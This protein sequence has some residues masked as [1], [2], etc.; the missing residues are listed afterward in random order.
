MTTSKRVLALT[1]ALSLALGLV[2]ATMSTTTPA[3]AAEECK[4]KKIGQWTIYTINN[5]QSY[6][7]VTGSEEDA[8]L[9]E[10][11]GLP[12]L[13]TTTTTTTATTTTTTTTTTLPQDDNDDAVTG[14]NT[15]SIRTTTDG[16]G[17]G[18]GDVNTDSV[19]T[20][21][22][23][24]SWEPA[25]TVEPANPS[26]KGRWSQFKFTM[27][28]APRRDRTSVLVEVYVPRF[29]RYKTFVP[30]KSATKV[31]GFRAQDDD[32]STI[33]VKILERNNHDEYVVGS[34]SSASVTVPAASD[35]PTVNI[36]KHETTPSIEE[37]G[38]ARFLITAD[39]SIPAFWDVMVD[40]SQTNG[41]F[42]TQLG[43]QPVEFG[44]G[45]TSVIFEVET[46][47]DDVC[48]DDGQII[49]ELSDSVIYTV[50]S[51]DSAIVPVTDD[52]RERAPVST[53]IGEGSLTL[54]P[55][56]YSFAGRQWTNKR[57]RT[58]RVG[59]WKLTWD[60][61][62]DGDNVLEANVIKNFTTNLMS[63]F[64]GGTFDCYTTIC[65]ELNHAIRN[66]NQC[67][68]DAAERM[69]RWGLERIRDDEDV[70]SGFPDLGDCHVVEWDDDTPTFTVSAHRSTVTEGDE[71]RFDFDWTTPNGQNPER[72]TVNLR[73]VTVGSFLEEEP[74]ST[75]VLGKN[76]AFSHR[77]KY[78]TL[79]LE[80]DNDGVV[81]RFG[82]VQ[83]IILPPSDDDHVYAVGEDSTAI[84][85]VLDDDEAVTFT[86]TTPA[87]VVEGNRLTFSVSVTKHAR[88]G[89]LSVSVTETG[90]MLK[91]DRGHPPTQVNISNGN[92]TLYVDTVNDTHRECPS[93]ISVTSTDPRIGSSN[94]ASVTV[95]D[96]E[97]PD[98]DG[99]TVS[100]MPTRRG[101]A[102]TE[103]QDASFTIT[104]TDSSKA[105]PVFYRVTLGTS[106]G[107]HSD[108]RCAS[109]QGTQTVSI[110]TS[111]DSV[112][113]PDGPLTVSLSSSHPHYTV[114]SKSPSASVTVND[115]DGGVTVAAPSAQIGSAGNVIAGDEFGVW[116][117]FCNEDDPPSR[118]RVEVERPGYSDKH[119]WVS[120]DHT[121]DCWNYGFFH[122][123]T[124]STGTARITVVEGDGYT[125]GASTSITITAAGT[126]RTTARQTVS[127]STGGGSPV[128]FT[129]PTT[130]VNDEVPSAPRS[131]SGSSNT[132]GTAVSLSWSVPSNYGTAAISG[133]QYRYKLSS[134][135]SWTSWSSQSSTSVT[136]SGLS[137]G[138]SY[139]FEVRASNSA[140][141]GEAA[142]T[143][144]AT[145]VAALPVLSVSRYQSGV[146]EGGTAYFRVTSD[147][148]VPSSISVG[149]SRSQ[150]G[151][152]ASWSGSGTVTI[153][154]GN[155]RSGW[156]SVSTVDD[157]T[158]EPNGSLTLTLNSGTGYTVGSPSSV[159]VTVNDDDVAVLPVLSVSRYQS[160]V[161]E[162]GTAYFRVTSD[163][164]VP[165]SISVGFS[166]SQSGSFASWSGSGT[167][168][169]S[170]GNTRSGWIAVTTQNDSVDEPNGSL[171]LTLNSG[172]GYTVG[173]PSSVSVT[174]NDDDV[175][176]LPVLSVSR[177]QSSVTEGSTAYFRVTSD[178][179]VPSSI[180][181]GFSRSQQGSFA[182]WSGSGTVT[183]SSG[184]T[185]SGWISVST[186][187][188]STDEPNGSLTL[189]LNSG[190][191]YTVGSPSSVSVT[192][193]D[194]DVAVLPVL[195]VSRYQS[196]VT[197]GSTAYFRV[198]S[199][200]V[201][202]SSISVGFSR[203]QQG[204]FASWSGSGT[205]TISSGNTRSGWISVST[206]NDS[207]DEP[208]G[209]LTL[210]LNSGTGYTV[211]SPSSVSVTVN[212]DD[213]AV[214]P[215][216][217]VSRYQSGVTEGGTAYF[218][219]TSD[220]SVPSSI[221]VGFS[222]S[223]SGSFASWSGSGTVTISSGNTRSGWIA[224]TTQN[225]SVDEP[226]GSL[227]LTLNSGTGYTVGSPSSA[228]ITVRDNDEAPVT[229]SSGQ[230]KKNGV[231]GYPVLTLGRETSGVT[232]GERVRFKIYSDRPVTRSTNVKVFRQERG[233]FGISTGTSSVGISAG[234]GPWSFSYSTT[235]DSTDESDGSVQASLRYGSYYTPGSPSSASVAIRDNDDP[236]AVISTVSISGGRAVTEGENVVFTLTATPR[237][238][239][240]ISVRV[241]IADPYSDDP[242]ITIFLTDYS[243]RTVRIGTSG[244]ATLSLATDDDQE[245]ERDDDVVATIKPSASE[246][247]IGTASA[248][249]R[250]RDNDVADTCAYGQTKKNGSCGYPILTVER[251]SSSVTE[252][253]AAQFRIRSDRRVPN[254]ISVNYQ[255]S[256]SGSFGISARNSAAGSFRGNGPWVFSLSTSNDSVD[257]PDGSV[258][259]SLRSGPRYRVGNQSSAT[260]TIRDNDAPVSTA[261]PTGQTRKNSVCGYPVLTI[262]KVSS[263]ITEGQTAN[264]NIRSDRR[265]PAS[266]RVQLYRSTSAGFGTSGSF[267]LGISSGTG[268]W[269]F[270]YLTVGDSVDEANGSVN[271]TLRSGTRYSVGSPWSARVVI[272]D[273]DSA[274]TGDDDDDD[275][276]GNDEDDG[277]SR[278]G[279]GNDDDDDED[280]A[281][282]LPSARA[283]NR[284][285]GSI[286]AGSQLSF[287]VGFYK[288]ENPPTSI[289]VKVERPGY[290]TKYRWISLNRTSGHW[291]YG[292]FTENTLSSRTGTARITV[293]STSSY[294]GG[295]T[296]TV[297]ITN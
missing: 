286:T 295:A 133:Y 140:G 245:D 21:T 213:V 62:L 271:M 90:N 230:A 241:H 204:S 37:G 22:L 289:R 272:Y 236:P 176:V 288:W 177:Y 38:V 266:L 65:Q 39:K 169:I 224:V 242:G 17:G 63:Y 76:D 269:A 18:T 47:P 179:V 102:I 72:R 89:I 237:P 280:A 82:T 159:S 77:D 132:A 287:W 254:S 150:Q 240:A 261:C 1:I 248:S 48:E 109:V 186:V 129:S 181:V 24:T 278:S 43:E 223:Q 93:T 214:L 56:T 136:I 19:T 28:P 216:L 68:N 251:V 111:D 7:A 52:D 273:D 51:N 285:S 23:G 250:V 8:E 88:D 96:Y 196:S 94:T 20:Q 152:F 233:N 210:T 180:S 162:G 16:T 167:V 6:Y 74:P 95:A 188:D 225:D 277:G 86:S 79:K 149:F 42:T 259:V 4:I 119:R 215:V 154:S 197:E 112:D 187:N 291:R 281:D 158:D 211:G 209:S 55:R 97:R 262:V 256:V 145:A 122:E 292:N 226:D 212:D 190:T 108:W 171:T 293:V 232:E 32:E 163:R 40:V 134:G 128:T 263:S 87:P 255:R 29:G 59:G 260:V 144:V 244:R 60:P 229:C 44:P 103:G 172:T 67:L 58:L 30:M 31:T 12:P 218:R 243:E 64:L 131:L 201:V 290:T 11:C 106:W 246:Y 14:V 268:P 182:S 71:V 10:R 139:D 195:S 207:T 3:I 208:N 121:Y 239:E 146:T 110:A 235:D 138:T 148:V 91:R 49:A 125:H 35:Y 9:R 115:D 84:V 81:E 155:T 153:S 284:N 151:S 270:G 5:G 78:R 192:V 105:V 107:A 15:N 247:R 228:S 227:T 222:R 143:T 231:C 98:N 202:P 45:D 166:R 275:D 25:V 175:A 219:V 183:I 282:L 73:I 114:S 124:S 217:S 200:K 26:T 137:P 118:V 2:A 161:T 221:S 170:S 185:R 168:T 174:V 294:H 100:I 296:S 267:S 83:L 193:N 120:I 238:T 135:S 80:T 283:G 253:Q 257:E 274:A 57:D 75:H 147:K 157:S 264:F 165:S 206:V 53:T 265:V 164:S 142:S 34:P 126:S 61:C 249:V 54:K 66:G 297:R 33:T 101:S 46:D 279:G 198:T 116:V 99:P 252:G 234:D 104:S 92:G 189:T 36:E 27:T 203:S 199:D 178:K 69:V 258:T 127:Y 160:G 184:N 191:G 117:G 41:P 194:D 13:T 130:T 156:I 276:D 50:G 173:S 123:S 141:D 85:T 220:R 113:E 205:V 70:N